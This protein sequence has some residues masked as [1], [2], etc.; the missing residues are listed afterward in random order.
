MSDINE[1]NKS[2]DEL[3]QIQSMKYKGPQLSEFYKPSD[4]IKEYQYLT[5][6]VI[7]ICS[8]YLFFKITA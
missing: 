3:R 4:E 2:L 8:G 7:G 5:T 6:G 1:I